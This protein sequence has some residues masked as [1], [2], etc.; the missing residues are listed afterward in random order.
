MNQTSDNID[1]FLN[2]LR[3]LV[4]EPSVV[5]V[6]DAFFRVLRRE[7]EEYPV[8]VT[9]YNGLLV[10]QGTEPKSVYLS[11]HVDRHG[12]AS[13]GTKRVSVCGFHCW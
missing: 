6:E 2:L 13:H 12:L 8:S 5:G 11:A 1:E 4:R 3:A 7:L 10:A 9:R